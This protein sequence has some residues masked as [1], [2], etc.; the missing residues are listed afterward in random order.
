VALKL[1]T[2]PGLVAPLGTV[3]TYVNGVAV[4]PV[5]VA[6]IVAGRSLA[7]TVG[8]FTV[9][10]GFGFTVKVVHSVSP[11][12]PQELLLVTVTQTL[13]GPAVR[14]EVLIITLGELVP[15]LLPSSFH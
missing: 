13:W 9:T 11:G 15:T 8:E 3:H 4:L 14:D 5:T 6:V 10:F 2:F 12:V 7:Q 1:A